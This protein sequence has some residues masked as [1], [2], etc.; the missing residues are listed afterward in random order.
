MTQAV[1]DAWPGDEQALAE[2]LFAGDL[3]AYK[4]ATAELRF[5]LPMP[6]SAAA[7]DRA[8]VTNLRAHKAFKDVW[9]LEWK[10]RGESQ[11]GFSLGQ[12][13][14]T[15]DGSKHRG[16]IA[17]PPLPG[18]EP[19]FVEGR[20][21]SFTEE[22]LVSNVESPASALLRRLRLDELLDD[23][24]TRFKRSVIPL[25]DEVMAADD[26]PALARAFL[27]GRLFEM[28]AG[29]EMEWGVPLSPRLARDLKE[30]GERLAQ[31]PVGGGD[32]MSAAGAARIS[33]GWQEYFGARKAWRYGAE[34][35]ARMKVLR[36]ASKVPPVLVARLD[37]ERRVIAGPTLERRLVW[38]IREDAAGGMKFRFAGTLEPGGELKL[39]SGGA[40]AP[41][42][43]LIS[44]EIPEEA[45]ALIVPEL[46]ISQTD[47]G[48]G[49]R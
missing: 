24:G 5:L 41:L 39:V 8:V 49:G 42:S 15:A 9:L 17:T 37:G 43:P 30:V 2:M 19:F 6:Q 46:G 28:V 45:L 13:V 21:D 44:I 36:N 4:A 48:G 7:G 12:L 29:R 47:S 18:G 16:S 3:V 25:I 20:L 31:E 22:K 10:K 11:R 32:W 35:E 34:I 1:V 23:S 40:L 14:S 38:G 27:L 26:A 33:A